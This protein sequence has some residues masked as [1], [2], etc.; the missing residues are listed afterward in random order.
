MTDWTIETLAAALRSGDATIPEIA[1]Q[2]VDRIMA[3]DADGPN[4]VLTLNPLWME[5]AQHLQ[6]SLSADSPLLH[7]IPILI[8]DN[9]DTYTM[10]NSAG[11]LAL[12]DIPVDADATLVRKLQSEGVLILGKTNLSE[13]ANFRCM[14]S[15]SGWS[16][17][18]G[19]TRNALN[20]EW[21]LSLIHI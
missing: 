13:W 16:S 14:S 6:N 20:T 5:E 15:V 10:G 4:A 8:K 17:L 9:I 11:S 12:K 19:Q 1:Q 2:Y 7:G 21:S 3:D 18:G